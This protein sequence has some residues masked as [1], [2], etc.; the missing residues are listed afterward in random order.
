M[1]ITIFRHTIVKPLPITLGYSL[2]FG[3][4][5]D[6]WKVSNIVP[7]HKKETSN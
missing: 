6:N 1:A 4:F 3:I 7:V 2:N 5:P